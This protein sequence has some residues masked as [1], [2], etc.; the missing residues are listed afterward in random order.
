MV[1]SQR[2]LERTLDTYFATGSD[3]VA[4]RVIDAALLNIDHIPQRRAVRVPWRSSDMSSSMKLATLAAAV[5]LAVAGASWVLG[6][7]G[8]SGVAGRPSPAASA[9]GSPSSPPSSAPSAI[10]ATAW[11]PFTSDRYG[12]RIAHPPTWTATAATRQWVL[13]PDRETFDTTAADHFIDT[14]VATNLQVLVTAFVVDVPAGT[15]EDEWITAYF[16]TDPDSCGITIAKLVPT[17]VD[18][19]PG[20]IA[21]STCGDSQA[22]VFF[23]GQVHVFAIWRDGQGALFDAFLSTVRFDSSAPSPYPSIVASP[24]PA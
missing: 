3:E 22:L 4:D 11:V 16:V 8:D 9:T 6:R 2:D 10:I 14:T 21:V 13:A 20:R 19:R 24:S 23:G 18:G 5:V 17:T 1:T 15:S 7:G 12:Y